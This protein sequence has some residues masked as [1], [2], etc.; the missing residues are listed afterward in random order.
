MSKY[1]I[2]SGPYFTVFGLYIQ[3]E[4]RKIRTRNS[5][6]GHFSRSDYLDKSADNDTLSIDGYNI[7]RADYPLNKKR[8]DVY[9]YFKEQLKLK[10][11]VLISLSVLFVR[12]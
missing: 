6:S 7:I 11:I 9:M 2:I 10:Q 12:Y 4:Y 3:S 8:G 1:G 5:V